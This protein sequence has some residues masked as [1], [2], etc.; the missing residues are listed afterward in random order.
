MK[1]IVYLDNACSGLVHPTILSRIGVFL[2]NFKMDKFTMQFS[3]VAQELYKNVP[4]ARRAV[5]ELVNADESEIALM[6]STSHGLATAV[7]AIDIEEGANVLVCDLEYMTATLCWRALQK[8]KNIEIR[9]VSTKFGE[10]R[11]EDYKN[12]IDTKTRAILVSSVQEVNG[13]RA[14]IKAFSQLAHDNDCYLIVDGVQEVGAMSVNLDDLDVDFYCS[15]GKKWLRSPFGTG[16]M[17]INKRLINNLDAIAYSYR[18]I[19]EPKIGR[20]AYLE[21]PDRSPFDDLSIVETACKFENGGL[22][23]YI[24]ALS[25][26]ANIELILQN[27][28]AKIEGEVLSLSKYLTQKLKELGLHLSSSENEQAMSGIVSF[29]MPGGQSE[30]KELVDYM[31]KHNIYTSI[32]YTSRIGG[33]RVSPH[34]YNTREEIDILIET[35]RGSGILKRKHGR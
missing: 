29:N 28:V 35:I 17:Y 21:S 7:N 6:E 1:S 4:M 32:R 31:F 18:N 22:P 33:I 19:K 24:G 3:N 9:E 25:L 13:F 27:G 23:N 16:F 34:Y 14:D 12:Y 30:E 5:S 8:K 11:V 10:V 2:E 15:G 26:Y 20:V